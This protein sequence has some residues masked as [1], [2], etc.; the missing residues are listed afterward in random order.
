MEVYSFTLGVLTIVAIAF[1]VAMVWGIVK[2][3]KQQTQIKNIWERINQDNQ[4]LWS[5]RDADRR[6]RQLLDD[7]LSRHLDSRFEDMSRT[8]HECLTES[9]SYTDSR[10]DKTKQLIKG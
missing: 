4:A 2:V 7:N 9:K 10:F 6:D 5:M 1:V 3:V 8:V